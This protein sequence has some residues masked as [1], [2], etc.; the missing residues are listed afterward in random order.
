MNSGDIISPNHRE[1]VVT[2]EMEEAGFRVLLESGITDC[3]Q[4]GDKVLLAEI[5]RAMAANAPPQE[6]P[7]LPAD[8]VS[9]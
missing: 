8:R 3:P 1:I 4:E 5:Y 7:Q 2:P 9:C 6:I